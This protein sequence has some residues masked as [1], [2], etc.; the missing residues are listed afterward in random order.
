M[1]VCV[2]AC[3]CVCVCYHDG[4]LCNYKLHDHT[5]SMTLVLM[6]TMSNLLKYKRF[7]RQS[8]GDTKQRSRPQLADLN[9][10]HMRVTTCFDNV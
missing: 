4:D 2:R 8:I 6:R 3:V 7:V 1:C 9:N 5:I 10:L